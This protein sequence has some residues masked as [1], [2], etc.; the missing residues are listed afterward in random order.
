ML[1]CVLQRGLPLLHCLTTEEG[2]DERDWQRWR[3]PRGVWV[4]AENTDGDECLPTNKTNH[5]SSWSLLTYHSQ[6]NELFYSARAKRSETQAP[7]LFVHGSTR[8]FSTPPNPSNENTAQSTT[9]N[10]Y[11]RIR[12]GKANETLTWLLSVSCLDG[13]PTY[14]AHSVAVSGERS[15]VGF[16]SETLLFHHWWR[17][18]K[19][20]Q[21]DFQS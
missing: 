9:K 10:K 14:S 5:G 12:R 11:V 6:L 8:S 19:A 18:A 7:S 17:S 20:E 2:A 13:L 16:I 3:L 1:R 4:W 21:R 15:R